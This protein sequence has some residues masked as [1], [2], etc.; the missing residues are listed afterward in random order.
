M[1]DEVEITLPVSGAKVVLRNYTTRADDAKYEEILYAGV[2]AKQDMNGKVGK[3]K[4]SMEFPIA[5]VMA[6]QRAYIPRLVKSIDGDTSNLALRLEQ[7]RTK[8]YEVI[9]A[10]VEKIVEA[11]SPKAKAGETA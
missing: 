5:N 9:E 6:A 11:N 7:L 4:A 10:E 1:Q 3:P 8:D 2:N